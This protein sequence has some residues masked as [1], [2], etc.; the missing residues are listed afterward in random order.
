MSAR[1]R[2][3]AGLLFGGLCVAQ[4]LLRVS[5][6]QL[7]S[8]PVIV[9]YGD[10]R[11]TDPKE[12]VATNP[13][14]RRWVVE[15]IAEEKPIA[16][17]LSGDIPYHG[18]NPGDYEVFRAETAPWREAQV[19]IIPTLG[20]HELHTMLPAA[21][22]PQCPECVENWWQTFPELRG[23][24]WYSVQLGGRI[25]VLN[26]DT[27]SP[28]SPGSDQMKWIRQQLDTLHSSVKFVCFNLHHPPVADLETGPGATHNPRPNEIALAN[29]L[30]D[31][32]ARAKRVRFI[33]NAGHIHNY[34]RFFRDQV[35]YLVSGGGGAQPVPVT[36][37]PDDL[38]RDP[39]FP[40][41]HYL[42]FV[43]RGNHLEAEMFRVADPAEATPRWELKDRF[44][45]TAR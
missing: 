3:I 19:L 33:V 29:F 15:K 43:L 20:N 26:L 30:K 32:A 14:V 41:Y 7:S 34:E 23:H 40:N 42:K 4:P 35:V 8:R 9:A 11:F 18:I 10:I 45:V 37:G 12:I 1:I 25:F 22:Q 36:R 27:T 28:L 16:I 17:L 39:S 38:Y 31:R 5:G 44:Q 13:K 24:R 2:F 21:I 6:R